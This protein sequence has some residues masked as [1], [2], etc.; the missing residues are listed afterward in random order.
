[1]HPLKS[2]APLIFAHGETEKLAPVAVP[3]VLDH[4]V[5]SRAKVVTDGEHGTLQIGEIP[6]GKT[7]VKARAIAGNGRS[8]VGFAT[9]RS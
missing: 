4:L 5:E 3:E 9:T 2:K 8:A 1:M 7:I 6:E